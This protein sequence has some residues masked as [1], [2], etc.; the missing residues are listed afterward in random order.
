MRYRSARDIA[1]TAWEKQLA[2]V[3]RLRG[4]LREV[5]ES[6]DLPVEWYWRVDKELGN[7]TEI[8]P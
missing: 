1:N 4:L 8:L 7:D 6:D 5:L 2:E 3:E